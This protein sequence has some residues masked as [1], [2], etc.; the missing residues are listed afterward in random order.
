MLDLDLPLIAAPMAG[1][2]STPELVA[3]VA[4]TGAGGFLAAGYLTTDAVAA[5]LRRAD[6]LARGRPF[7]INLFVV[8]EAPID[9]AE[10][11][12]FAAA[13]EP[14]ACEVGVE[15]AEP[16]F[17]DDA[18]AAK[19]ELVLEERPAWVSFTFGCPDAEVFAA[20]RERDIVS[21]MTVTDIEEARL[22]A[23]RGADVLVV[24]GPEAGGHRGTLR[25]DVW[26]SDT[27]LTDLL[28]DIDAIGLPMVAAGGIATRADV[29]RALDH[30]ARA[31]QIGTALLLADEAGTNPTHRAALRSDEFDTTVVT[32]AFTG[33]PARGLANAVA[34][35]DAPAAY[36]QLHTMT[37]AF[38]RAAASR[39]RADLTHLWAGTRYREAQSGP[40]AEIISALVP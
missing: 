3:A 15:L 10:L 35:L 20:L 40:A 9:D 24:Q 13:L 2:P 23:D 14:Y 26:P 38:R 33:R 37:S 8:E 39:G 31:A 32:R 12:R 16:R 29:R 18:F 17:D 34:R 11:Q 21:A 19:L 6:E 4:R 25:Q 28:R 30:G 5:Q 22:A 36:P 27:P 1:G 7:G